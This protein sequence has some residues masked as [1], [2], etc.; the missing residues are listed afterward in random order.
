MVCGPH[1]AQICTTEDELERRRQRQEFTYVGPKGGGYEKV[2]T[3]RYVGQGQGDFDFGSSAAPGA[4]VADPA[5]GRLL[6]LKWALLCMAA[7]AV[8][9]VAGA[10]S[11]TFL[12]LPTPED[13]EA[14]GGVGGARS[15]APALGGDAGQQASSAPKEAGGDA[16]PIFELAVNATGGATDLDCE[17][18]Y[19]DWKRAWTAEKM[20]YCCRSVQRGC[21]ATETRLYACAPADAK[22][23]SF[24][25]R[26]WCCSHDDV[27]CPEAGEAAWSGTG[28]QQ[29]AAAAEVV[30]AQDMNASSATVMA[31]AAAGDCN[32][33]CAIAALATAQASAPRLACKAAI[34]RLA[35]HEFR[36]APNACAAGHE[37]VR[38]LC[39]A[40]AGCSLASAGCQQVEALAPATTTTV[41]WTSSP[42]T[43]AL[44]STSAPL[45]RQA[46]PE[47]SAR[48]GSPCT[49]DNRTVNCREH[50]QALAAGNYAGVVNG[51]L[52]ALR[53]VH[54]S[55]A[56]CLLCSPLA[57]GCAE[58]APASRAYD[59]DAGISDFARIWSEAKKAWCCRFE[60]RG[61]A[62]AVSYDCE[63]G[64][65][66]WQE[67]WSLFRKA[68]CC[69]HRNKACPKDVKEVDDFNC[70]S[71]Y[72]HWQR[73]WSSLKKSWCCQHAGM[74]CSSTTAH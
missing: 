48:C 12:P 70:N 30:V 62:P 19:A 26:R 65:A 66:T 20:R 18:G 28:I 27:G 10:S 14:A 32:A 21:E 46:S 23:W 42:S 40:C 1:A 63:S 17:A 54:E 4:A 35:D 49:L 22:A 33:P 7:V 24:L 73:G 34:Q 36:G 11:A 6:I 2:S 45:P 5:H 68:W 57:A 51:C 71:G 41:A 38:G 74:G 59:C 69:Q 44:S 55:C 56:D 43:A 53:R 25:Q 60:H 29:T 9:L 16:G 64:Y 31:E 37:Q 52:L 8:F 47:V 13:A 61:C 15:G 67:D 50:V 58:W 72:A 3:Y 39:P